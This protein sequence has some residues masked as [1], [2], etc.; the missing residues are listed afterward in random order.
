MR[1]LRPLMAASA[2]SALFASAGSAQLPAIAYTAHF[3]PMGNPVNVAFSGPGLFASTAGPNYASQGDAIRR[4]YGIDS[5]QG[6]ENQS[7]GAFSNTHFKFAQG[8]AA[9]NVNQDVDIGI[10][11]I[12]F[13]SDSDLGGDAC[14]S[15]FLKQGGGHG[16]VAAAIFGNQGTPIAFPTV[17]QIGYQWGGTGSGF[18][19]AA[20]ATTLGLD[21]TTSGGVASPL[22]VNVIYEIQG[23]IN[24]GA[25]NNQYYLATTN[26]NPGLGGGG[27]G[28]TASYG[29]GGVTNGNSLH[30]ST[31]FGVDAAASGAVSHTRILALD[32]GGAGLFVYTIAAANSGDT[33]IGGHI[34]FNTPAL[35]GIKDG[36]S[37]AGANDWQA[38]SAPVSVV[39]LRYN[40]HLAGAETNSDIFSKSGYSGGGPAA[41]FNPL[42]VF[43]QPF[44]LWSSTAAT[45]MLQDPMSWDDLGG[46]VPAQAGSAILGAQVTTRHGGQ[47][48]PVNFDAVTAALLGVSG[49]SLGTPFTPSDDIFFDGTV[50]PGTGST[51]AFWQGMFSTITDGVSGISAGAIPIVSSPTAS[52]AGLKIGIAALGL[53]VDASTFALGITEMGS[54]LTLNFQ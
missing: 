6:G 49:L 16:V 3:Q 24:G 7:N 29:T 38:S 32:P 25:T 2:A 13:A 30:G 46:L 9:N 15:P 48:I 50:N 18:T 17:W 45:S 40:D 4:C 8:Y 31:L 37:G 53:Q 5:T 51:S 28:G 41:G 1:F 33:E 12:Q 54:A 21:G 22:L 19:G 23:P 26:E 42:I 39:D 20:G 27:F 47:T 10:G 14:F 52:F 11:S 34:A 35:W 43:N 36:S 44:F